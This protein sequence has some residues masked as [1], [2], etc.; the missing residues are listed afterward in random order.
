MSEKKIIQ[1]SVRKDPE[2]DHIDRRIRTLMYLLELGNNEDDRNEGLVGTKEAHE[3]LY[4]ALC[5]KEEFGDDHIVSELREAI[6]KN[7]EFLTI[8]DKTTYKEEPASWIVDG[9]KQLQSP[10]MYR[11]NDKEQCREFFD[12]EQKFWIP[13][14]D[15]EAR[16]LL[17]CRRCCCPECFWE[18]NNRCY[19]CIGA[20][21]TQQTKRHT[22]TTTP[23]T[24]HKFYLPFVIRD[25][26][27]GY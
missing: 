2:H 11:D 16:E 9:L 7:E 10:P 8:K 27:E 26:D 3:F 5:F 4:E 25:D 24:K 23:C 13:I 12:E 14:L 20:P 18:H 15:Y 1:V 17:A 19:N 6:E 21:R 22:R